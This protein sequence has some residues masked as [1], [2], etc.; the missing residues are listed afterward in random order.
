MDLKKA[1]NQ[2][3]YEIANNENYRLIE[4]Y[5]AAREL[6]KRKVKKRDSRATCNV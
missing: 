3:L 6:Q 1:T 5:A 4:R 2:Q